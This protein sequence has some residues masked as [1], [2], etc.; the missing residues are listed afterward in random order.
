VHIGP[1]KGTE[2]S[3]TSVGL[4]KRILRALLG[5]D[6]AERRRAER[7]VLPGLVAYYWDGGAP[8]A[9]NIRDISSTGLFLLTEQRW[10]LGTLM[11]ITLQNNDIAKAEPHHLIMVQ[12]KV[13]QVG[14][15]G[16]GFAFVPVAASKN[17]QVAQS[18]ES[19]AADKK[20]IDEFIHRWFQ[21]SRD[22]M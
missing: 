6:Y 17:N 10:Y 21:A 12:A 8:V 13:V 11:M 5:P 2:P 19:K 16:V 9:H 1:A 14:T 18:A 20:T 4:G 7:R 3:M 15:D 22:K